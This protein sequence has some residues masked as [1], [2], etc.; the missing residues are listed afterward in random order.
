[1]K[2]LTAFSVFACLLCLPYGF[3][4][5]RFNSA[6]LWLGTNMIASCK[7]ETCPSITADT[8][9]TQIE[10]DRPIPIPQ[11][12]TELLKLPKNVKFTQSEGS[13]DQYLS[14]L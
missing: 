10:I 3:A 1:M 6:P 11:I 4:G 8:E 9:L 7:A 14:Y 12:L 13:I 2:Y 5:I